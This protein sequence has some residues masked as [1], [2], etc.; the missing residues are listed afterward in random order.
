MARL[1]IIDDEKD[2]R[3]LLGETFSEQGHQIQLARSGK[4]GLEL[5]RRNAVDL[6]LTDIFMP[7]KDGI[8][9][10]LELHEEFPDVK[11]IAYSGGGSVGVQDALD[12]AMEFGAARV[13]SKPLDLRKLTNAVDELIAES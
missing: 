2:I 6:V 9:T 4:E 3:D 1:L 12:S 11:I 7:E 8:E 13:F 5:I 10:I